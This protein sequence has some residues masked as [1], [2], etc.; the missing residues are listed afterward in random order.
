M[1]AEVSLSSEIQVSTRFSLSQHL[2]KS[3]V[4]DES[5][6]GH[7]IYSCPWAL[8]LDIHR[9]LGGNSFLLSILENDMALSSHTV[10]SDQHVCSSCWGL[11]WLRI[12]S[13]R[14]VF[15]FFF[16]TWGSALLH[17]TLNASCILFNAPQLVLD[18]MPGIALVF[19]KSWMSE[20][21][22]AI[23]AGLWTPL[24]FIF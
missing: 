6:Y 9:F 4:W 22:W 24:I 17:L 10:A 1:I 19:Y 7:G 5:K 13:D 11:L 2:A 14:C 21:K 3:V 18:L 23:H 8:G 20:I 15:C 16:P 12:P